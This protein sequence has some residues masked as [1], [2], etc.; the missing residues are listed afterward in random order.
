MTNLESL[1]YGLGLSFL[2]LSTYVI[3]DTARHHE[4]RVVRL[5]TDQRPTIP[6]CD[7]EIFKRIV[8]GCDE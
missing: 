2:L 1:L 6:Y 8:E 4:P 3:W 7:K 5:P